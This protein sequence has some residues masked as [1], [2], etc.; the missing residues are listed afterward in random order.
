MLCRFVVRATFA[1]LL[2]G[3]AVTAQAQFAKPED[4]IK[5]RQSAMFI[6]GQHVSRIGAMVQGKV[7]WDGAQAAANAGIVQDVAKLPWAGFVPG[8]DKGE[9]RAKPEIWTDNTKFTANAKKLQE[10]TVKLEAAAKTGDQAAIKA[11]FGEVG[12]T[13]KGCHDDFRKE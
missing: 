4:A 9:T 12:K 1:T 10:E 13:C 8:T 3:T 7:P 11:Q 6:M 5:Y 2:A